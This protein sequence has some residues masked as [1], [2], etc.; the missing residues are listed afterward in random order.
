MKNQFATPIAK[1]VLG[2]FMA[3]WLL[4]L[5]I[6]VSAQPAQYPLMSRDGGGVKPNIMLTMDDSGSMT[7]SH[8]P[9]VTIYVGAYTIASPLGSNGA[10]MDPGEDSNDYVNYQ[11][12]VAA[13]PGSTNH[14]QKL[15]RSPDTNTV[16][17]NPEVRYQ[18]WPL[19]AGGRMPDVS[20]SAAPRDPMDQTNNQINLT[21]KRTFT[22]SR[23]WCWSGADTGCN[24]RSNIEYDP[25]L[26]YRLNKTAG[27]YTDPAVASNYTEYSI[28][29][30]DGTTFT[31]YAARTDCSGSVCTKAEERQN[32]ANWFTYY[33]TRNLLARG[34]VAEAFSESG[35]TFR[36]GWGRINQ[37]SDVSI[38]GVTTKVIQAGVRDFTSTIKAD[39]F[40]WL[41]ALP[42]DGGTPLPRAVYT[43][44]QYYK[45]ADVRGPWS[46]NPGQVNTTTDKACRRSYNLLVTDGYWSGT[47]TSVGNSDNTNGTV[48]T[49]PGRNYQYLADR[50]FNDSNSDTLADYGMEFWKTD[51]RPDLS[52][53]VE[54]S[55]ENPAFWQHMVNL[56]VGLGVRGTLDPATDLVALTSGSKVWG[57]DRIDDLWHTALNSRGN[58]ISAKDPKELAEAIRN[59]VGQALTRELREAGV[60]TA[61]TVLQAG[62]RKYVPLYKSG[63]WNGDIQAF[64]LDELGQAGAQSW[65]AEA[66]VPAAA[67]RNIYTWRTDTSP[68]SAV[69]FT[70]A[71]MGADN[72]AALGTVAAT[73]TT[74]FVDFLRGNRSKEG[75]SQPFRTRKGLLGDFINSN[76]VLVKDAV[77]LGYISLPPAQGGGTP[78]SNFLTQKASRAAVLFVGGNDGMLHAFKDTLGT[79]GGGA[80]D[81]R[82]IFAY[83]PR[84][85]Y[86]NLYKLSDKTY[87]TTAMYHQYY[88]DGPLNETDAYVPAP[89]ET[90]AS[91]RNYMLG[92]LGAGGRAVF[93]LDITNSSSLD[94]SSI[95]WEISHLNYPDMGYITAP[96]QAG[97]LPNGEWVAIFGNGRFSDAGNAVLFVVNLA[98]G[99]AQTLTLDST[100]SNGLGGVGV[101]R[102]SSGQITTIYS[103]DL[104]GNLWKMDYS[105]TESSRFLVSGGAAFFRAT[106]SA[107]NPQPITQAPVIFD[108]S[109]GG[110]M[111]LF[112]TGVLD[113]EAEANSVALQSIYSVWD[114]EADTLPRPMD[115]SILSLRTMVSTTGAGGATFYSIGGTSV[116]WTSERG[117]VLDMDAIAGLRLIYPPQKATSKVALLSTISPARNLV[118]CEASV[119]SGVNFFFDADNGVNPNTPMYDTNG[120]GVVNTSDTSV[121]GYA[122]NADGIDAIVRGQMGTGTGVGIPGK[123]PPGTRLIST[124][125]TTGQM[126]VCVPDDDPT[127]TRSIQ[128]RVWRRIINPPIR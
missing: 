73:H 116:N 105:A 123:C 111:V 46:D 41:Y 5:T 34:S 24:N 6:S 119:G 45:R 59:S 13:Q 30:A 28:N 7:W 109:R 49:G 99:V 110:R 40:T 128:D 90:S 117:W 63:D 121:V 122:T 87:G 72:Q 10:R 106:D 102:N 12:T 3:V 47:T 115:R 83:V 20:V 94:G 19:A 1:S 53:I 9:E 43:V 21:N 14:R 77:N 84:S 29:A 78:Y 58:Y 118:V 85:V 62:N 50:P 104:K 22:S 107:L 120:D 69:A 95:R 64:T 54:P 127:A 17:Y 27:A 66:K 33:R 82:E 37:G 44:G 32:F 76:P 124:Q 100:G 51:L 92:T 68:P 16:Y 31:K 55:A 89:G 125:N 15:M 18:P 65:N 113:V 71:A 67:S 70:W 36:L 61:S 75:D 108:T 35:D 98:T 60:A 11:G 23:T 93:A 88:V 57:T 126:M 86:P 52:N 114:K 74:D 101:V 91:W 96:V 103:G 79:V 26:Y 48:I 112:G 56:T 81:G 39:L 38:D 8:M 42:A 4:A 25:G 97:V 80:D 2:A